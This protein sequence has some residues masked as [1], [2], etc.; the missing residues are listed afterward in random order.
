MLFA[1][2]M[3]A[4]QRITVTAGD[5][6]TGLAIGVPNFFTSYFLLESLKSPLFAKHSAI[7]YTLYSSVGVLL[8]FCLGAIVW[9]EKVTRGNTIGVI[10]ALAA[11]I[12]LSGI[13]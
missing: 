7:A 3:V 6:L 9:H 8:V 2:L 13:G 12:L 4:V 1:W 5:F 11:I 10:L